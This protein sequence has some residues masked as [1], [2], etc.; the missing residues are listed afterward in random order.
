MPVISTEQTLLDVCGRVT[1]ELGVRGSLV[2]IQSSRP[3]NIGLNRPRRL[4]LFLLGNTWVTPRPV[5]AL[6][7]TPMSGVD[8]LWLDEIAE[9]QRR[10]SEWPAAL[11]GRQG[12]DNDPTYPLCVRCWC[13]S[14]LYRR[15]RLTGIVF[16]RSGAIRCTA[17]QRHA[18][19]SPDDPRRRRGR[20]NPPPP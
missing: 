8:Y 10:E 13:C 1:A 14:G 16:L 20:R 18:V 2:R 12:P 15:P 7:R 4:G 19:K 6:A 9:A 3:M 5:L 17:W 11:D